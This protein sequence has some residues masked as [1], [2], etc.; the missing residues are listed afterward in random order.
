MRRVHKL[1]LCTRGTTQIAPRRGAPS[2]SNKPYALTRHS[3]EV[4]TS[5]FVKGSGLQLGRD[6]TSWA[7][8]R[9][10]STAARLSVDRGPRPSSSS[11]FLFTCW[12]FIRFLPLCQGGSFGFG[13]INFEKIAPYRHKIDFPEND[14]LP[15]TKRE[16]LGIMM[17][18]G[19]CYMT[20]SPL[21]QPTI[22]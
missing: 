3:R 11:L 12:Y 6:G 21:S 15:L 22:C 8:C 13:E 18:E 16:R 1:A 10:A 14:P 19:R 2:G 4:S 20:V 17:T 7:S 5:L 9:R